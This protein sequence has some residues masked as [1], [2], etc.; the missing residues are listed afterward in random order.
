MFKWFKLCYRT[1]ANKSGW[2]VE[3]P[4]SFLLIFF[5]SYNFKMSVPL[6]EPQ[7][8]LLLWDIF[9]RTSNT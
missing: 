3:H 6:I 4:D 9:P 7:I 2:K 8:F 1:Q 5:Y